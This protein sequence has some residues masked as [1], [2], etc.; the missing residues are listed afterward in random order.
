MEDKAFQEEQGKAVCSV[1]DSNQM[2]N[3]AMLNI[4]SIPHEEIRI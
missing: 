2:I 3:K 1:K 4:G